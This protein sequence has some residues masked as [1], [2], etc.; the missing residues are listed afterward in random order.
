MMR[1]LRPLAS[2]R[3]TTAALLLLGAAAFAGIVQ[4]E[5]TKGWIVVPLALLALNLAAAIACRPALRRGGLGLFHVCL[6]ACMLLVAWGRLTHLDG[7]VRIAGGQEFDAAAVE[8]DARGAWHGDGLQRLAF[9]Q[10]PFTVTY[11]AGIKRERT[12]SVVATG[13]D[14][15]VAWQAVGDD[16]P[17]DIDGYRFYTTPNKGFAPVVTWTAT[18]AE[19]ITGAVMLPSYPA[20]DVLAQQWEAPAG[21]EWKFWLR[22]DKAPE[23]AAWTLDPSRTASVLVAES[24]GQRFELRPGDEARTAQGTLRYE[25]LSGWMGYRIFYDP[26]LLPLF[27]LA[28]LGVAGMAWH[29]WARGLR[30]LSTTDAV[31]A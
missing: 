1:M 24:A 27:A 13:S 19:P 9:R 15:R 29:L 14:P 22:V 17:L 3:L 5:L 4:P 16:T 10:G 23:N 28:V 26:T 31:P 18:G 6:L 21:A 20:S 2:L 11:G 8:V 25:W 12:T 30:S 7:R